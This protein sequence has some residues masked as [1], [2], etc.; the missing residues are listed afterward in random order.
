MIASRLLMGTK[1]YVL[2][3]L[4][5]GFTTIYFSQR[6]RRLS[7]EKARSCYIVWPVNVV[8]DWSD[9]WS[10]GDE[11]RSNYAIRRSWMSGELLESDKLLKCSSNKESL[12]NTQ[13]VDVQLSI[14]PV[15][16]LEL[17]HHFLL[18]GSTKRRD[19]R[20]IWHSYIMPGSL[21]IFPDQ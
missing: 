3:Y 14:K 10:T 6:C 20:I 17:P 19:L 16:S 21:P 8:P 18:R 7:L 11:K 2:T 1:Y 15:C 12:C 13:Q 9:Q 5:V 4:S